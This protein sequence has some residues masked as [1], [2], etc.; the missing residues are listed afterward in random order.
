[1]NGRLYDPALGRMLSPDNY[2]QGGTQGENRYSY[3]LNNPLKYTDPSG[4]TP[5]GL[6]PGWNSENMPIVGGATGTPGSTSAV[7]N[8]NG[9]AGGNCL[10]FGDALLIGAGIGAGIGIVIAVK[11]ATAAAVAT[12]AASTAGIAT[13]AAGGTAAAAGASGLATAI[14]VIGAVIAVALYVN[15]AATNTQLANA[16]NNQRLGIGVNTNN[17]S[18]N[19]AVAAPQILNP[20]ANY[21]PS[22]VGGGMMHWGGCSFGQGDVADLMAE[23]FG[24]IGRASCRERV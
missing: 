20:A 7:A 8:G 3:V 1:M 4:E 24:E 15:A 16:E 18:N 2:T 21:T 14:P 5:A 6:D 12:G 19:T 9:S 23:E 17:T 13:A 10:H 11:S 22:T